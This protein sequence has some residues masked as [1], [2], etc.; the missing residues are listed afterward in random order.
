MVHDRGLLRVVAE[1]DRRALLATMTTRHYRSGEV[2]FHEGD[3]GDSLHLIERGRVAVRV[4]T[5]LGDVATVD[6]LD[7]VTASVSRRC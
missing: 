1:D 7:R 2:L 6:V 4:S 5:T 3:A